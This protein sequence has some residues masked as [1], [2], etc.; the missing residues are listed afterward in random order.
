MLECLTR[1]STDAAAQ[2]IS[3]SPQ[4]FSLT[5]NLGDAFACAES[6]K[7]SEYNNADLPSRGGPVGVDK[8]IWLAHQ[9]RVHSSPSGYVGG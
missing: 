3:I 7:A 1:L 4:M 2:E 9:D 5:F 6:G 8:D